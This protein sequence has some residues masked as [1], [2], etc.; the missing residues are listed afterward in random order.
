MARRAGIPALRLTV[1]YG[2]GPTGRRLESLGNIWPDTNNV[3]GILRF[4]RGRRLR[5]GDGISDCACERFTLIV[6]QI[7]GLY[8]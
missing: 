1:W 4:D 5:R 2:G 6:N 3:A 8:K 7:K